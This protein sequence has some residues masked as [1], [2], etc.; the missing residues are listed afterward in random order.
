M[1]RALALHAVMGQ[2]PLFGLI[3][4][5]AEP[6]IKRGQVRGIRKR[7][8]RNDSNS[9]GSL[10][11]TETR[12]TSGE[13]GKPHTRQ[14]DKT[15]A[16]EPSRRGLWD[17]CLNG[18]NAIRELHASADRLEQGAGWKQRNVRERHGAVVGLQVPLNHTVDLIGDKRGDHARRA[19]RTSQRC[20]WSRAP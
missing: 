20:A 5:R 2:G 9:A 7:K 11:R 19:K 14:T 4:T 6:S 17:T 13:T 10:Q 18:G 16:E 8:R 1:F 15:S 3:A 12:A